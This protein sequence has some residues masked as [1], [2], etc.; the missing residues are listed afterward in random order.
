MNLKY[1]LISIALSA[2]MVHFQAAAIQQLSSDE[3]FKIAVSIGLSVVVIGP[4]GTNLS[5]NSFLIA[6][7]LLKAKHKPLSY[8]YFAYKEDIPES[9]KKYKIDSG[10][11]TVIAYFI[12]SILMDVKPQDLRVLTEEI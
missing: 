2:T 6:S 7:F 11:S 5:H 8:F 3:Q 9:L 4:S 1:I 10:S 12:T